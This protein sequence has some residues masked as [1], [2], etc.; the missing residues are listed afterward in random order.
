MGPVWVLLTVIALAGCGGAPPPEADAPP[1]AERTAAPEDPFQTVAEIDGMPVAL[2]ELEMFAEEVAQLTSAH[3]QSA[4]GTEDI[5]GALWGEIQGGEA[6]VD[7]AL[8]LALTALTPYKVTQ[9][10]LFE[11]GQLPDPSY[12]A[13][14]SAWET[15]NAERR[16]T[17]E[18]GGVLYGPLQYTRR[19]YYD[20]LYDQQYLAMKRQTHADATEADLRRLY[21]ESP[22]L[23]FLLG[24]VDMRC[25]V[26]RQA[27]VSREEA[28]A[29]LTAVRAALSAG[30][31]FDEAV[32]ETGLPARTVDRVFTAEDVRSPDVSDFPQVHEA[33]YD[34]PVGETTG[35]IQNDDLEWLFLYCAERRGAGRRPFEDCREELADMFREQAF[36][37]AFARMRE[38]ARV[39][40]YDNARTLLLRALAGSEE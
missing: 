15:E 21:E 40:V 16:A 18:S 35:L 7:Y 38:E 1:D 22:D 8:R 29:G 10:V 20:Y 34:L 23:F 24:E 14:V 11:S 32:R 31:P 6:P 39:E 27:D 19:V 13:F 33:L 26:L 30:A 25:V 4:Y 37:E 9:R 28:E 5:R 2:G 17:E 36:E 12:R 3:F